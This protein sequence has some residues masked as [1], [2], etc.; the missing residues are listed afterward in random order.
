MSTLEEPEGRPDR[1]NGLI[2]AS[3]TRLRSIQRHETESLLAAMSDAR[4][5]CYVAR[6]DSPDTREVYVDGD[7]VSYAAAVA[8]EAHREYGARRVTL[9]P[10]EV[11]ARFAEIIGTLDGPSHVPDRP[12]PD[13][14]AREASPE[15]PDGPSSGW[16]EADGDWLA[17][18]EDDEDEGYEPPPPPPMPKPTSKVVI[19]IVLLIAGCIAL[20]SPTVLPISFTLSVVIGVVLI[21]GG[22]GYLLMQLRDRP[23]D[24]F[25]DGARV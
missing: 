5:A 6:S 9:D 3:Y 13:V 10:Q 1:H 15:A 23:D 18:I 17:E 22:V 19:G 11:D 14:A 25:D 4:I 8:D 2:A 16:R 21:G 7:K 12:E 24:P 20:F